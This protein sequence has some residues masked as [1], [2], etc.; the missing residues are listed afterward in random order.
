MFGKLGGTNRQRRL[1]DYIQNGTKTVVDDEPIGAITYQA[2]VAGGY[3]GDEQTLNT[4]LAKVADGAI[5]PPGGDANAI[6][7]K[8]SA[9]NYDVE[10]AALSNN[11]FYK[12]ATGTFTNDTVSQSFSD[13]AC[14]ANS[15][16]VVSI[17]SVTAPQGIWSVE[18]YDGYFII[19]ST[20]AETDDIT[21]DY[22]IIKAVS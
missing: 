22:F 1:L 21:F 20:V 15:L 3:T 9:D 6:L 10:W 2:L 19:T 7:K 8:S 17:T 5:L 18:S 16:V 13:A 12:K 14:T 11:A 4:N